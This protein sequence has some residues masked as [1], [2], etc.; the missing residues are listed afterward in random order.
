MLASNNSEYLF[1]PI[2]FKN[3]YQVNGDRIVIGKRHA[4]KIFQFPDSFRPSSLR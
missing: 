2:L 4:V 3:R 1:L